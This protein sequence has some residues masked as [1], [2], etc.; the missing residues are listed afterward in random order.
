MG[1]SPRRLLRQLEVDQAVFFSLCLRLWQLAAGPV[2]VLLIGIF[3]TPQIQGFYYTFASLM[4]LQSFFELGLTIVITNTCSHEWLHLALDGQGRITGD[5]TALSRLVSLGRLIFRWYGWASFLFLALVGTWGGV[6]LSGQAAPGIDWLG[7]WVALVILQA[8]L[9]W[10]MPFV[11][12]L[13][14]CGQVGTVTRYRF[15]QAI[16][17]NLAIWVAIWQGAGLWTAAIAAAARLSWDVVLVAGRFRRFFARFF[18]L[19]RGP[20]ISWKR[21]MWPMQW[22]LAIGGVFG[23]FSSSLLTPVVF[24]YHGP[25][26]AGRMGMTWQMAGMV[27]VMALAWVQTRVPLFGRL[28]AKRDFRELDRIFFRLSAI[29]LAAVVGGSLLVWSAVIALHATGMR[30]AQRLL[31]PLPTALF[32]AVV[33]VYHLPYCQAFYVRA[34]KREPFLVLSVVTNLLIGLAIWRFGSLYGPLG[35]A[36]GFLAVVLVVVLP[37][38]TWIWWRCRRDWGGAGPREEANGR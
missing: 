14:G 19:P 18:E 10:V 38:Q 34:F 7:G 15:Y 22:R 28:V 16:G 29:S 8:L 23:Y 12:I 17:I 37:W 1:L 36:S 30:F 6:F 25:E 2:S 13:E 21:E 26:A 3:F 24:H 35:A 27:Q 33:V 20:I 32:L 11:S 9:L 31:S 4:A 5:S